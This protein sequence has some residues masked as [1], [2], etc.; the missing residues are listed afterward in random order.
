MGPPEIKRGTPS[1]VV[2]NKKGKEGEVIIQ[3]FTKVKLLLRSCELFFFF[4]SVVIFIVQ[5]ILFTVY[6]SLSGFTVNLL[7]KKKEYELT[8]EQKEA[9]L[10]GLMLADGFL[11]R[12]T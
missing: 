10:I 7:K 11:E 12:E 6:M 1:W 5:I 4:Y 2:L 8:E 3:D 9:L